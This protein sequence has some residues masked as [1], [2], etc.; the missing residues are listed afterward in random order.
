[1]ELWFNV[2]LLRATEDRYF[3]KAWKFCSKLINW[4]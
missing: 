2:N 4:D 3:K 1:M